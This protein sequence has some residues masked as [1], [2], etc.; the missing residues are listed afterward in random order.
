MSC[1]DKS[2]SSELPS[3]IR[4]GGGRGWR[5]KTST[6]DRVD[7]SCRGDLDSDS[8]WKRQIPPR[9]PGEEYPRR[10]GGMTGYYVRRIHSSLL[11]R[12][13]ITQYPRAFLHRRCCQVAR[14]VVH[15]KVV[16]K[17]VWFSFGMATR[18]E[19]RAGSW[20]TPARWANL[21][22]LAWNLWVRPRKSS[23]TIFGNIGLRLE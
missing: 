22:L 9:S 16:V 14:N 11:I 2:E 1:D 19:D 20:A 8:S 23:R 13:P 3:Q 4:G 10:G 21:W 15:K 5:M 6:S 12:G 7:P 18:L 17:F